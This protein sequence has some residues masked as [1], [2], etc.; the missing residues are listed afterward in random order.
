MDLS[1]ITVSW[2]SREYLREC[3]QSARTGAAGLA[4]EH[5]VVDNASSDGGPEFL[6][7]EFPHVV[8]LR[9]PTNAGFGPANNRALAK[10][11]GR[12]ILFL[13]PDTRVLDDALAVMVEFM[14][15]HPEAG[16]VG[17]KLLDAR[18][19][20]SPD[21]GDRA[22]TL[23]TVMNTYLIGRL[24]PVPSLFPGIVRT[25]DLT[26][27]ERC[28][29]VSGACLLIRRDAA[30]R[31]RWSESVFFAGEDI[32]FCDRI[33]KLGYHLFLLPEAE[34]IHYSGRSMAEQ[35]DAFLAGKA[36]GLAQYLRRTQGPWTAACSLWLMKLG[37]RLRYWKHRLLF[38]LTQSPASQEKA[39]RIA[40]FLRL[41]EEGSSAKGQWLRTSKSGSGG[42]RYRP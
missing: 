12:F 19:R 32:E 42:I 29:W 15:R 31:E 8:V 23:R 33:R 30:T 9:N 24:A 25:T 16:G 14:D 2:N 21:M 34:V 20:W 41:D 27:R 7:E 6:E 39:R 1:I 3:I 38:R 5:L 40:Q 36:S 4:C 17:P 37:A 35:M 26:K 11:R 18:L 10:A 22:P 13:N 28:E